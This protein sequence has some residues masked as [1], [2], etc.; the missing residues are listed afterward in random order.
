MNKK[1][2]LSF[3]FLLNTTLV[4]AQTSHRC[5]SGGLALLPPNKPANFDVG[6]PYSFGGWCQKMMGE[7]C[8]D[9]D[10][11]MKT[12]PCKGSPKQILQNVK[13][14]SSY[15][16]LQPQNKNDNGALML[17]V[18]LASEGMNTE[19]FN[20][21]GVG[22][23]P[24]DGSVKF[25]KTILDSKGYKKD[26]VKGWQQTFIGFDGKPDSQ[27]LNGP[28]S[29]DARSLVYAD[30]WEGTGADNFYR[31]K[32]RLMKKG[33]F[34]KDTFS[35]ENLPDGSFNNYKTL[36]EKPLPDLM[37]SPD[38]CNE[39]KAVP[40]Y[41]NSH[42]SN[43]RL[44]PEAISLDYKFNSRFAK[45]MSTENHQAIQAVNNNKCDTNSGTAAFGQYC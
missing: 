40:R 28:S 22:T 36:G 5:L 7:R 16:S 10:N 17:L 13:S 34:P 12:I 4:Q 23:P 38:E 6:N 43:E 15:V 3:L 8:T 42:P 44:D 33:L 32:E 21:T 25:Q 39:I 18:G 37:Y 9:P 29:G 41:M 14:A 11:K 20:T 24:P 27:A 31:E 35:E 2:F 19:D 1:L 30:S 45:N 26:P